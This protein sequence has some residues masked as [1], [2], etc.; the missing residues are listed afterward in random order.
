MDNTEFNE[1]DH[2][3]YLG[4][5]LTRDRNSTR[6]I[7]MRIGIV[8]EAFNRKI[9]LLTSKLNIEVRKKLVR[10]FVWSITLDTKT[11]EE[12]SQYFFYYCTYFICHQARLV[13][14]VF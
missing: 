1:W 12:L 2:F 8:K 4:S 14:S 5:V 9:S 3:K 13:H 6:D 7:K 11:I 10:C